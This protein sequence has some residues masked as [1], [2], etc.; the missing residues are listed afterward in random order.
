MQIDA[1][2]STCES[3][4]VYLAMSYTCLANSVQWLACRGCFKGIVRL[5]CHENLLDVIWSCFNVR[6]TSISEQEQI[7]QNSVRYRQIPLSTY[8]KI[9]PTSWPLKISHLWIEN[10]TFKLLQQTL[11]PRFLLEIV[12]IECAAFIHLSAPE[13]SHINDYVYI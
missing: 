12:P 7:E 8:E 1:R 10:R 5:D 4:A 13:L 3:L 2:L 11:I 9:H 6:G